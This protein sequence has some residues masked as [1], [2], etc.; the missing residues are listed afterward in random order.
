KHRDHKPFAI[1]VADLDQARRLVCLSS[2][3]ERLLRSPI[4]PIVLA[5]R[6]TDTSVR[7]LVADSV[8]PGSHRL[9]IMLPYTP[10][11]HLLM[12]EPVL[13]GVPLVMTSA[14]LSDDP[15]IKDDG[16][17]LHQL[18]GMCDA[19][20]TH[21]RPI[22]RAVDDS[23]VT[24]TSLGILPI[25][26]ARGYVPAPIELPVE[27]D[28]PGLCVG[29]ELKN[30]AGVARGR[31]VILSQHIGDL[32]YSLAFERFQKTLEDLQRLFDVEAKW[33]AGDAHPQ[34][35]SRRYGRQLAEK[36]GVPWYEVQHHHAHLASLL[37]EHGWT[38]PIIGLVCDGV[39]YGEDGTAWGGEVLV[40][41][42]ESFRRVGRCGYRAA[43]RRLGRPG[44]VR[45]VGCSIC[46]AR[47]PRICRPRCAFYPSRMSGGWFSQ[48][49]GGIWPVRPA[50]AW[51]DF[52]TRRPRCSACA[53]TTITKRW[54]AKGWKRRHRRRR[55][56]R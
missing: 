38:E 12:S 31:A 52:S 42:L 53:I 48:C 34:Y 36:L 27:L 19:F 47:T 51:A 44:D 28:Q 26:R 14:N 20:L 40:G 15:L 41:G 49:C 37:A 11:Q 3:A 16:E 45:P 18:R 13:K 8:A 5:L 9:G 1:M 30:V 35:L 29:G 46:S 50:Q 17:A 24:D 4:S 56:R 22:E 25:R 33:V 10:M 7:S 21:D 2:E 23:V 6:R 39:G 54:Q 43:T 55:R 32:T